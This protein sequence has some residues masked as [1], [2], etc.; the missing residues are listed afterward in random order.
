MKV[1]SSTSHVRELIA[2]V[3]VKFATAFLPTSDER[4]RSEAETILN[5]FRLTFTKELN[6]RSKARRSPRARALRCFGLI[7]LSMSSSSIVRRFSRP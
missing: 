6:V 2:V 1:H 3:D 4:G 5:H 7:P